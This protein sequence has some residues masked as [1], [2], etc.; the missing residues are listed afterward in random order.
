MQGTA[1]ECIKTQQGVQNELEV[2]EEYFEYIA[3]S[4]VGRTI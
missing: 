1:K 4:V 3:G 2:A